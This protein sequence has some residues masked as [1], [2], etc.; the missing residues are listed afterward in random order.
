MNGWLLW[1]NKYDKVERGKW[2][3][4]RIVEYYEDI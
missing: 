4:I 3:L 1:L 2:M